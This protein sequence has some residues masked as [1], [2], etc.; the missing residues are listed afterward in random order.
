MA[1]MAPPAPAG[2]HEDRTPVLAYNAKAGRLFLHDRVQHAD[3]EWATLKTD[4]T[5]SQPAFAVDFLRLETGWI[6]F[7][8]NGPQWALAPYGQPAPAQPDSPGSSANGKTL[9]FK[10]GFRVPVVSRAIGGVREL[11]GNS[12]ALIT[13]MNELH[14]HYEASPEAR[15]GKIPVVKLTDVIEIRSGQSSNFQP[16]F[17]IQ[18]WVERPDVLGPRTVL[19]PA[20]PAR[21]SP[22]P[23]AARAAFDAHDEWSDRPAMRAPPPAREP[24]MASFADDEIPF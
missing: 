11:A 23:P 3:G 14:T 9:R 13:G 20:A 24:A 16:V 10:A 18:L 7:S 5:M 1:F 2:T 15:A 8:P 21:V 6:H 19:M 12:S 22:A 17:T 4:V